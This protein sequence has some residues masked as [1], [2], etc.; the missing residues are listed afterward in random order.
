[1]VRTANCEEVCPENRLNTLKNLIEFV[2]ELE[3]SVRKVR[4][5]MEQEARQIQFQ[6]VLNER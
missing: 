1:M 3:D 5:D 4:Q 6:R 2:K